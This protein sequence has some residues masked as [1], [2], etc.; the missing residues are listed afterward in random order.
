MGLSQ[1]IQESGLNPKARSEVGAEGLG[2][3]MPATWAD[4][5]KLL[6]LDPLTPRTDVRAGIEAFA[7]YQG[8]LT[9]MWRNNRTPLDAHKPGLASYNAGAGTV[10]KAQK[11]C[12]DP[13]PWEKIAP[14][15]VQVTGPANSKQT[16]DYVTKIFARWAILLAQQ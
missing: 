6:R 8:K 12:S 13:T 15:V 5:V 14:C 10:L 11:L 7:F 16:L 9:Y 4:I 3:F 2:Q 1:L